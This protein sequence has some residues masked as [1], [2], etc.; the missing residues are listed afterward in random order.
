MGGGRD[1]EKCQIQFAYISLSELSLDGCELLAPLFRY[2]G[3][4]VSNQTH[5][6]RNKEVY[7]LNPLSVLCVSLC[8]CGGLF[9][10]VID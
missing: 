8:V 6:N 10:S 7:D 9:V 3:Y 5:F 1:L 2:E 4:I